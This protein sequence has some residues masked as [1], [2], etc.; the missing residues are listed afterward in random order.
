[1]KKIIWLIIYLIFLNTPLTFGQKVHKDFIDGEVYIKIKKE[2]SFV[3]DTLH[4]TVDI[5]SRLSFLLPLRDKYK[6][7]KAEASF[8]FSKSDKLQ[9]IFRIHFGKSELVDLL[10][11]ELGKLNQ[12][13]YA[14]R[15][16]IMRRAYVPNDLQPNNENGQYA[17]YNVKAR[18]AWDVSRGNN[19]VV[20]AIVDNAI[21]IGHPDLSNSIFSSRDVSDNDDDP[22]PPNANASWNHGT[23]TAGI[24]CATTDNGIGISSIGFHSVLMAIK[25]TRDGTT[26]GEIDH[27]YEGISWAASHG[28]DVISCSFYGP[29]FSQTQ[30]NVIDNAFSW[31]AVVIACAGNNNSNV[32]QYPAGYNHVVAVASVDINDTKS[33]GTGGSSF[34]TWVDV[35]APGVNILSTLPNNS[36][37]QLSGTSMAAPLVAG[38]CGL[39]VSL[40]PFL[41]YDEVVNIIV[42]STD[43]INAKN[44]GFAGQ[45]GTGRINAFRAVELA[46]K[47]NPSIGLAGVYAVPKTESSGTITSAN[48][49]YDG[50]HVIFDAAI[51]VDL[52]N[53]F[54]AFKGSVFR[55]YID[56]CGK[57]V[58]S[59]QFAKSKKISAIN[60]EGA[61]KK[62]IISPGNSLAVFPNPA[63]KKITARCYVPFESLVTVELYNL[64]GTKIYQRRA[65]NKSAGLFKTEIDISGFAPGVYLLKCQINNEI[66][67]AKVVIVR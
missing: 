17:L 21:D 52:I 31:N 25:A 65:G 37:G 32:I 56:G 5:S 23:H 15:I 22:R 26:T 35:A 64:A 51:R 4:N 34:G 44:P 7:T 39:V 16:P 61:S 45:L 42:S 28:A 8:Y 57:T 41:T 40:N 9:R 66:K 50:S 60:S 54:K 24:A 48:V 58:S 63:N 3:F 18:E 49:I 46:I 36:Y 2:V 13:E 43:N 29:G 33:S 1:M 6:I 14:E 62:D 59:T 55:A 27:A 47:C 38:L 30:Q 67:T 53:G 20:V 19:Q 11:A 10:L 12:I